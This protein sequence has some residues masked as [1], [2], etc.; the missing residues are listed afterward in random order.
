MRKG[1]MELPDVLH[2]AGQIA[3]ALAAS[4]EH[5]IL[6]RD[7][8]PD[9]V[10]LIGR[11]ADRSFVKV[12]DFGLAKL[13]GG[14]GSD[15]VSHKT[16]A[17]SVMGTPY[18]MAPEQCMGKSDVD[19]RADV[20]ALGVILF[21]MVCG[22]VPFGG[23][24]Y[25]EVIVKHMT[26]PAPRA[27]SLNPNCP[28]WLDELIDRALVKE[29][30][31]RVQSMGELRALC[32]QAL[33]NAHPS[34]PI[35]ASWGPASQPGTATIVAPGGSQ[36]P[37]PG[38]RPPAPLSQPA[39][40]KPISTIGMSAGE[41]GMRTRPPGKGSKKVV[42]GAALALVLGGGVA[43][44]VLLSKQ[45]P[46]EDVTAAGPVVPVPD[47]E[48]PPPA[49][50]VPADPPPPVVPKAPVEIAIR[51]E[52]DPVGAKVTLPD[53]SLLG[54]TPFDWKLAPSDAVIELTFTLKGHVV[55]KRNVTPKEP[56]AIVVDLP[57]EAPVST[58]GKT[59]GKTGGT[60]S[61]KTGKTGTGTTTPTGPANADDL[62]G[63]GM[64]K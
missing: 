7:L 23:E 3:E 20:Y 31:H 62:M 5:N 29:P 30:N 17:G 19:A 51:L 9:N 15:K 21:E 61:G 16:R 2:V 58:K 33:Q 44:A 43:A 63:P 37:P 55:K 1:R 4:H 36:P 48:A 14:E 46:A 12:L 28:A 38:S 27:V 45:P 57:A 32:Y 42:I 25:G 53:G 49:P 60:T 47:P 39:L 18:Y 54:V 50:P 13:T 56:Y 22:Q 59:S 24:G 34:Q 64:I 10:F 41:T 8:K 40:A 52:S 26:A 11:G 35:I 6:H